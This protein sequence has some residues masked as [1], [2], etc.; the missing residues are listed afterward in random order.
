MALAT[1]SELVQNAALGA[2]V[3][4]A[5]TDEFC[6]QKRR[7]EGPPLT[8]LLP[9]LPMVMHEETV[10]SIYRRHFDGGLLLAIADDRTMTLDLQ[11]RM[12]AMTPQTM[13]SLN[14]AFGV[15]LLTYRNDVG[16]VWSNRRNLSSVSRGDEIKPMIAAAERLGYW[17]ATIRIEQLCSYLRIRF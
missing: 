7:Q 5:F 13:Q 9:V 17:F 3:L 16:Q 11:E 1:E 2:L 14:L 4:W 15:G 6:D 12:E 8:Y 10:L